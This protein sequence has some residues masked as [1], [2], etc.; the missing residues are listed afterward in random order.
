LV[1]VAGSTA[2]TTPRITEPAGITMR[3]LALTSTR[4][5][6]SNRSSTC[7]VPE[8]SGA[9]SRTSSSVP[10][11]ISIDPAA[12]ADDGAGAVDG[13]REGGGAVA[14]ALAHHE[15]TKATNHT[16]R[17]SYVARRS[18]PPASLLVARRARGS[19]R[20]TRPMPTMT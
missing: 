4:V 13:V 19:V 6:A 10:D 20:A 18:H 8:F 15:A 3:P 16:K 9:C 1:R 2:V 12:G 11:G 17:I 5:V 7:V 14:D